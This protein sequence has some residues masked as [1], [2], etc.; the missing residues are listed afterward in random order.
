MGVHCKGGG[1][2]H[3]VHCNLEVHCNRGSALQRRVHC[4]WGCIAIWS[5]LQFGGVHCMW[6]ALQFGRVHCKGGVHCS[7][8]GTWGALHGAQGCIAKG[9]PSRANTNGTGI[10][11][12]PHV[13]SCCLPRLVLQHPAAPHHFPLPPAY[14]SARG[15]FGVWGLGFFGSE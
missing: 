4:T 9:A 7:L 11:V 12:H 1:E 6:G 10:G 15:T 5:A 3:V 13:P 8:G 14:P 2:L